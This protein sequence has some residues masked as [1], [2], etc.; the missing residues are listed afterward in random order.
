MSGETA[1][2]AKSFTSGDQLYQQRARQV[3]PILVR[4]ARAWQTFD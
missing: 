3:F 2:K 4:Q 1:E